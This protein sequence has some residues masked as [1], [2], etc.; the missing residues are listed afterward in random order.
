M[1][2]VYIDVSHVKEKYERALALF[3]NN[4][5]LSTF[6]KEL[7]LRFIRDAS[8]GKTILRGAKKKIGLA[9]ITRYLS[10][11]QPFIEYVDKNLDEV[12]QDEMECFIEALETDQILSK[13]HY[14]RGRKHIY[15]PR[16]FS[17]RYKVDI[18]LT[19][20]KFYKWL[21]GKNKV[22]PEI[23]EW[24]DTYIK[25]PEIPALTE[26][27]IEHMIDRCKNPM[28]RALIQILF[29]GGF[30]IGEL[31]NIRLRHV[32]LKRLDPN[33]PNCLYY[34]LRVPF[35]KTIPRTVPLYFQTSTKYL[36]LWLEDHPGSVR[37][38]DDGTIS[39]S[40]VNAQLFPIALYTAQQ[41]VRRIG[42]KALKKR[43]YPH[44]L[45][46]SSATYWSNRLSFFKLCK[47]FGWTFTSKQPQRYIDRNG[48]DEVDMTV[49]RQIRDECVTLHE[50]TTPQCQPN[51]PFGK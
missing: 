32:V 1:E 50:N 20:K 22:Y 40:N 23:V 34:C 10:H 8:L 46:H 45:R 33:N 13:H 43:V 17:P 39:A 21:F 38:N 5:N 42:L 3:K 41:N 9:R 44:L 47:R 4:C 11:L 16:T 27:E 26:S 49:L 28:Q 30:R 12:T 18:K 35:S 29:D 14:L 19:I 6:N 2:E 24:I 48:I 31:L 15:V 7:V 25:E 36:S 37:M 51:I